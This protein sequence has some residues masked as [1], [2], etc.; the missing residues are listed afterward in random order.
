M[1]ARALAGVAPA[2]SRLEGRPVRVQRLG[3][4][5]PHPTRAGGGGPPA[6]GRAR[7]PVSFDRVVRDALADLA[8]PVAR[9]VEGVPI[10]VTDV[11]EP[12]A[13]RV[14]VV[15]VDAEGRRL[16]RLTVHRRP[17]EQRA[18]DRL[19][20][21]DLVRDA[22]EAVVADALGLDPDSGAW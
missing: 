19:D 8:G 14:A 3:G 13:D 21:T 4:L 15:T 1:G 18:V 9:A 6:G 10:D 20:L 2:K 17:A 16:R 22:I 11:P 7:S 5:P 12:T